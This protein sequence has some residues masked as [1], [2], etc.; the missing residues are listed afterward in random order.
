MFDDIRARYRASLKSSD[1]EEHIDLAF[2]RPIGFTWAIIAE[3]LGITPNAITIASIF[4]GV[5][6]GVC[7]Y[8]TNI[9]INIAGIFCLIL[10]NSFDSADGQLA[11]LT[12]QYSRLGR[13]LDGMAGDF[14]FIA[15]Y[16]AFCL[17]ATATDVFFAEHS[18]WIW[19][20]AVAAGLCHARQ[21]AMADYFRQFH[22]FFVKKSF[23]SELEDSKKLKETYNSKSWSK[24]FFSKLVMMFYLNYTIMQEKT[25][26]RMQQLL[27]KI[28]EKYPDGQISEDFSE[29]FRLQTLPLCKWENFLTFN[30]RSI[31]IF[32]CVLVGWPWVYFVVELTI[33]NIV[34][35]YLVRKHENIC[36]KA[37]SEV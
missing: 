5:A 18:A 11:R 36:K 4:I 23:P 31:T 17:R 30:W 16:V 33:F 8:P 37:Y 1:T 22:L 12:K 24:N 3:R 9:W 15:I 20:I 32:V 6:A 19:V 25:T 34:Y 28:R 13:I 2:Y 10:A 27:A 29:K 7:F 35:L 26:P 21:A 14:W